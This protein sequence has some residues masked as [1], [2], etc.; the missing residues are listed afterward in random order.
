MVKIDRVILFI[1]TIAYFAISLSILITSELLNNNI[2]DIK[3]VNI[4]IWIENCSL[5][6]DY[7]QSTGQYDYNISLTNTTNEIE[8]ITGIFRESYYYTTVSWGSINTSIYR[9]LNGT[10]GT[11]LID[12]NAEIELEFGK[13]L[14]YLSS[15]FF[16]ILIIPSV[17]LGIVLCSNKNAIPTISHV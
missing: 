16:T 7:N 11:L 14:V 9:Y 13:T 12:E 2:K 10:N 6:P 3:N 5:S 1:L 4:E 17:L 15:V 8:N